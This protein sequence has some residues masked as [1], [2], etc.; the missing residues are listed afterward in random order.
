MNAKQKIGKIIKDERIRQ[1]LS[2]SQLADKTWSDIR[3]QNHISAIEKGN[4]NFTIDV[5]VEIFLALGLDFKEFIID[6]TKR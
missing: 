6:K 1:G 5:L 3:R 4:R 2:L